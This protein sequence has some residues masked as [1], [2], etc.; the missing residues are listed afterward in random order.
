[1]WLD[2]EG[3]MPVCIVRTDNGVERTMMNP[4]QDAQ[5]IASARADFEQT[6]PSLDKPTPEFLAAL[7]TDPSALLSYAGGDGA[8]PDAAEAWTRGVVPKACQRP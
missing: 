1:M 6:G 3:T 4:E 2:V 5:S 7:P 8:T